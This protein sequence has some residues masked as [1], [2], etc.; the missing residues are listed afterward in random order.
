VQEVQHP[1]VA[2][3]ACARQWPGW[4]RTGRGE[5]PAMAALAAAA[6]RYAVVS[7]LAGVAFD[8]AAAPPAWGLTRYNDRHN[9]NCLSTFTA[10]CG[11]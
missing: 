11:L 1:L 7:A 3:F 2:A 10:V 4:C 5:G 6:P 8:A 9:V